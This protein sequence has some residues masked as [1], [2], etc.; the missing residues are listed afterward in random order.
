MENDS[1]TLNDLRELCDVLLEGVLE[2]YGQ[3]EER[4]SVQDKQFNRLWEAYRAMGIT[5]PEYGGQLI[6]PIRLKILETKDESHYWVKYKQVNDELDRLLGLL[7]DHDN[8][9]E[10]LKQTEQAIVDLVILLNFQWRGLGERLDKVCAK[11]KVSRA[12]ERT[13]LATFKEIELTLDQIPGGNEMREDYAYTQQ[14]LL[15][16]Q[17]EL[18]QSEQG[19]LTQMEF[20]C[21][22]RDRIFPISSELFLK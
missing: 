19:V 2:Q 20:V 6:D 11:L 1:L 9:L 21:D 4:V 12:S 7:K 8:R 22:E 5:S 13:N 14:G 17:I 10:V 18:L 3:L 15:M 16:E